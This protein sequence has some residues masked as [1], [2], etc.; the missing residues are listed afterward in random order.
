MP[1]D[2]QLCTASVICGVFM[3]V[4]H[5]TG[6]WVTIGILLTVFAGMLVVVHSTER[7][8]YA[9][10]QGQAVMQYETARVLEVVSE[11]ITWDSAIPGLARG[12][13]QLKVKILSGAHTGEEHVIKNYLSTRFN[14]YGTPGKTIVVCVDT[15]KAGTFRITVNNVHRSPVLYAAIAFFLIVLAVTGGKKG[16]RSIAGLAFTIAVILFLFIPMLVQ[17]YS[18]VF[19]S[20]FV[21]MLTTAMT[22]LCINGWSVKSLTAIAGTTLGVIIAGVMSSVFGALAHVSGFQTEEAETLIL[23]ASS[24][25]MNVGQLLFAGLLIASLGAVMDVAV[26]ISA[27]IYEVRRTNPALSRRRLFQSG[28]NMGRDI[29]GAMSNTLILAFAGSA[30]NSLILIYAYNVNYTQ[31]MNLDTI[32]IEILRGLCGSTAVVLTVPI[33]S[34]ISA[35]LFPL[36]AHGPDSH[37]NR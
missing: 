15:A 3:R 29:M 37:E 19:T 25:K 24:T 34:V 20:I 21:V 5:S 9:R 4:S 8:Q 30:I 7:F 16:I 14:V 2:Y 12:T 10:Q 22:V 23:I 11:S 33:V 28:M 36:F 17:G 35:W 13:Q 32:A 27:G 26:S 1:P 6:L 18:P 31:L